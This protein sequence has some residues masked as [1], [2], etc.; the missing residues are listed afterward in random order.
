MRLRAIS[1][2]KK[3]A[4]IRNMGRDLSTMKE[5]IAFWGKREEPVKL[6]PINVIERSDFYEQKPYEIKFKIYQNCFA[7]NNLIHKE[8]ELLYITTPDQMND[9]FIEIEYK[10][11]VSD[12]YFGRPTF[13]NT[14]FST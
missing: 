14:E 11:F 2:N 4:G 9:S 8:F 10:I 6:P 5:M 12:C 13:T 7:Y 1:E 3:P